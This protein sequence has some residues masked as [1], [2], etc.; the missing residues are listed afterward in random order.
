MECHISMLGKD[1][2]CSGLGVFLDRPAINQ[3]TFLESFHGQ[4]GQEGV[5]LQ[6]G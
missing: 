1:V 4:D 3:E 5:S 6:V 2:F